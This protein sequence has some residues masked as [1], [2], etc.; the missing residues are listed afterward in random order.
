[1]AKAPDKVTRFDAALFA[2]AAA[3]GRR[4]S[5]SATQQLDHWARVGKAVTAATS[6]SR[7]RVEEALAGR[8]PLADL[9]ANEAVTFNAEVSASVEELL[10]ATHYGEEL[11]AEGIT[12]VA[13]D[14]SGNLVQYRP[15]GSSSVLADGD[16]G[17]V[18]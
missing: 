15:D 12:T 8:V 14:E 16:A 13:L 9:D 18:R 10:A 11:A 4:Q 6:A 1:M 5:R 17:A 3:E 7:N 2:D